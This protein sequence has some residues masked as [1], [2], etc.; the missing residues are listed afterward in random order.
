MLFLSNIVQHSNKKETM[1]HVQPMLMP[2]ATAMSKNCR[3]KL[4]SY[5]A[6]SKYISNMVDLRYD[7][8]HKR[9]QS[10]IKGMYRRKDQV[11]IP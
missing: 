8:N 3:P 6:Y 10:Y 7:S 2:I 11:G 5:R 1:L 9:L 4:M